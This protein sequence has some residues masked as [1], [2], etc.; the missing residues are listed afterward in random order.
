MQHQRAHDDS[1]KLGSVFTITNSVFNVL[2]IYILTVPE[3]VV[4]KK[5][6]SLIHSFHIDFARIH[7]FFNC[8]VVVVVVILH[9]K[10]E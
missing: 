4:V 7:S 9:L 1:S 8:D 3:C 10:W 6:S 2:Q 5:P